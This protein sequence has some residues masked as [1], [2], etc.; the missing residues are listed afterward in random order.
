MRWWGVMC[1]VGWVFERVLWMQWGVSHSTG[2]SGNTTNK[3]EKQKNQT[4]HMSVVTV[5]DQASK[6]NKQQQEDTTIISSYW[7]GGFPAFS[8]YQ[9]TWRYIQKSWLLWKSFFNSRFAWQVFKLTSILLLNLFKLVSNYNE[10]W[11]I[12]NYPKTS[13]VSCMWF[14]WIGIQ[15]S[16]T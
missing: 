15:R 11:S 12:Q 4:K 6:T 10:V 8:A 13:K 14:T 16:L 5:Y 1:W 9:T 7:I 2:M 3:A